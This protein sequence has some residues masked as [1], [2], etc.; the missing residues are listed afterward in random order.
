MVKIRQ[1]KSL[2]PSWLKVDSTLVPDFVVRDPKV[3]PVLEI[4]GAEFSE[5]SHHTADGISVRFPRITK[6]RDDKVRRLS[7]AVAP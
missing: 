7:V 3:S 1:D 6:I 2:V 5:S 4:T